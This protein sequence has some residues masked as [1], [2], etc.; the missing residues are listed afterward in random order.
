MEVYTIEC[1]L[2]KQEYSLSKL[3]ICK[4]IDCD[5]DRKIHCIECGRFVHRFRS[6]KFDPDENY[7]KC[8]ND[9]VIPDGSNLNVMFT[10]SSS[11]DIYK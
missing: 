10:I 3:F 4:H 2:C 9:L 8:V 11:L 1:E 5:E 7:M 6:H